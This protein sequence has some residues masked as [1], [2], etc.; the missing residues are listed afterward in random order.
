MHLIMANWEIFYSSSKCL[1]NFI[2]SSYSARYCAKLAQPVPFQ[3]WDKRTK[4]YFH[5]CF[6]I[7]C[8]AKEA[9]H[10]WVDG[11]SQVGKV[12]FTFSPILFLGMP[13]PVPILDST[14]HHNQSVMST[15]IALPCLAIHC[16]WRRSFVHP[17][18]LDLLDFF[19]ATALKKIN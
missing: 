11:Y 14:F 15:S 8:L 12:S 13:M 2:E 7:C 1:F 19:K 3:M 4:M 9:Q 18:S 10:M 5:I 17:P 16:L 6:F